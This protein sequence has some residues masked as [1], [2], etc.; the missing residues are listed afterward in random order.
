[1][2]LKRTVTLKV[3]ENKKY[4]PPMSHPWKLHSFLKQMEK[5]HTKHQYT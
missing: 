4:L 2:E 1:M 3:K 5:S